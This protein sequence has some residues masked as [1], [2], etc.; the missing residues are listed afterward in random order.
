MQK[1]KE[2]YFFSLTDMKK[3]C[4]GFFTEKHKNES[5]L[6]MDFICFTFINSAVFPASSY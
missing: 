5:R 4:L 3:L 1:E 2:N 6:I